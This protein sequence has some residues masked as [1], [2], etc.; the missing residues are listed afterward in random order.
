MSR[1]G[2]A[3]SPPSRVRVYK[4]R[5][6]LHANKTL[7]D[8]RTTNSGGGKTIRTEENIQMIKEYLEAEVERNPDEIGSSAWRN[9]L[10]FTKSSF[11]RITKKDL[12][13][14]PFQIIRQQKVSAEHAFLR[15]QMGRI[16]S[17]K[18]RSSDRLADSDII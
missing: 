4:M 3:K 14:H 2:P 16:L 9:D 12:N 6:I 17:R 5:K 8:K 13:L 15:L 11:N 18:P 1:N 7:L 10:P